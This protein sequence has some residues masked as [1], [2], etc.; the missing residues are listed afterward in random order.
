M[1]KLETPFTE[2]REL[3]NTRLEICKSC[4]QYISYTTMCKQC[5]CIMKGKTLLK[6]AKC[7]LGK[8]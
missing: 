4:D 8:W 2:R 6:S 7:P 1:I 3:A 5:G